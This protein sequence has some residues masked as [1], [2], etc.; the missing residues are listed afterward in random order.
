[1]LAHRI[2]ALVCACSAIGAVH[3]HKAISKECLKLPPIPRE[4]ADCPSPY[5]WKRIC[6]GERCR[7]PSDGSDIC[8]VVAHGLLVELEIFD[9]V[10][11]HQGL[12]QG[13]IYAGP[14][15]RRDL[16]HVFPGNEELVML[17]LNA[18]DILA[19][20]EYGIHQHYVFDASIVSPSVAGIRFKVDLQQPYGHR[21][22]QA[23]I[24]DH[25]CQWMPPDPV[26]TYNVLTSEAL[27]DK[28]L[29]YFMFSDARYKVRTNFRVADSFWWYAQSVCALRDP[30]QRR[31]GN[32]MP[33]A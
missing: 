18:S 26:R 33:Q 4:E 24:L 19:A 15:D 23:E 9:I 22:V 11:L 17:Q 16:D 31:Y 10:F 25:D 7:R 28:Q 30:Y 32:R 6:K 27:I 29:G 13:E 14:F 1:M 21:V 8:R 20:L 5:A 2:L 12:C 3:S